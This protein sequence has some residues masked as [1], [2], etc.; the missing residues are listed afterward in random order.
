MKRWLKLTLVT[1][2]LLLGAALAAACAPKTPPEDKNP[3]VTLNHSVYSLDIGGQF[4]LTADVENTQEAVVWT[5]SN[6][7]VASVAGGTVTGTGEGAAEITAAAGGAS[8]KCVVT[9]SAD[10][11]P[12]LDIDAATESIFAGQSLTLRAVVTYKGAT[13]SDAAVTWT[14][15]DTA[16]ATVSPSGVLTGVTA[17]NATVTASCVYDGKTATP[18]SVT[19]AVKDLLFLDISTLQDQVLKTG[20]TLQIN[21]SVTRND[22]PVASP[23]FTYTSSDAAKASVDGSGLITAKSAGRFTVTVSYNGEVSSYLA[24]NAEYTKIFET[25][26]E[27]LPSG[28]TGALK[29]ATSLSVDSVI[30]D[31]GA[32][33]AF[34]PVSGGV[35]VDRSLFDPAKRENN[36]YVVSGGISYEAAFY[37]AL[38]GSSDIFVPNPGADY[39]A[40]VTRNVNEVGR[41]DL[42]RFDG[43]AGETWRNDLI[44]PGKEHNTYAAQGFAVMLI[45]IYFIPDSGNALFS[46]ETDNETLVTLSVGQSSASHLKVFDPQYNLTPLAANQWLTLAWDLTGWDV[47]PAHLWSNGGFKLYIDNVRFLSAAAYEKYL[48][49]ELSIDTSATVKTAY[50][51]SP[52]NLS[53][54][55]LL[56]GQVQTGAAVTWTVSDGTGSATVSGNTLTGISKG[57]VTV[58]ATCAYLGQTA[59]ASFTAEI[60]N[61]YYVTITAPGDQSGLST[62]QTAQITATAAEGATQIVSP[63]FTY[64]SSDVAKASVDVNGLITAKSAG[65]VTIKV[66]Y[67]VSG[68][69]E[70]YST[71]TLNVTY[72][73]ADAAK[74]VELSASGN[75]GTVKITTAFTV[76]S[77][78]NA[79]GQPITLTQVSGGYTADKADL[80][81]DLA[82][83]VLYLNV[84][85]VIYTAVFHIT[86]TLDN[87]A[88]VEDPYSKGMTRSDG[89]SYMGGSGLTHIVGS[90]TGGW[91][92]AWRINL[93]A[94]KTA[95]YTYLLFDA[96]FEAQGQSECYPRFWLDLTADAPVNIPLGGAP[97]TGITLYDAAHNPVT[98]FA[99][100]TLY[101][102]CID[103]SYTPGVIEFFSR[104]AYEM[105]VG[106]L[107]AVTAPGLAAFASEHPDTVAVNHSVIY[108]QDNTVTRTNDVAYKGKSGLVKFAGQYGIKNMNQWF[109]DVSSYKAAGYTYVLFDAYFTDQGD[110]GY[111]RFWIG[112]NAGSPADI[113][114]GNA[115]GAGITLYDAAHN[116]VSAFALDTW[117]TYCIDLT[118]MPAGDKIIIFFAN[119]DYLMYINNIRFA[120]SSGLTAFTSVHPAVVNPDG[121]AFLTSGPAQTAGLHTYGVSYQGKEDLMKMAY[122][123]DNTGTAWYEFWL[124]I[125]TLQYTAAGYGYLLVDL[126]V[127]AS[128][129]NNSIGF[130][131]GVSQDFTWTPFDNTMSI[132]GITVLDDTGASAAPGKG[133]WVTL[134]FDLSSAKYSNSSI[135]ILWS[136]N[137]GYATFYVG[138][139]RFMTTNAYTDYT[140][141]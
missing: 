25:A 37:T 36:L 55:V 64:T 139:A 96:R 19:V 78:K 89:V 58:T 99:D 59:V 40:S 39:R 28:N 17:G 54:S 24:V 30:D 116:S 47:A 81:P 2:T 92:N 140:T 5:T 62:G 128:S 1:V 123:K 138:N 65:E 74:I 50:V 32:P 34:A 49:G 114:V 136:C 77:A 130:Q 104:N 4:T 110:G 69:E 51:G 56:K 98:A 15:S 86:R 61:P 103:L 68:V 8:A 52:V 31:S 22:M 126:W 75:T 57:S 76:D 101:T 3:S 113:Q 21:A 135:F 115:P 13:V 72:T 137:G 53:A 73:A 7:A 94:Y 20:Q 71:V 131:Y 124:G 117:Y 134:A 87:A 67:Y 66:S 45:D 79:A 42:S 107:R 102:Y 93:S 118:Q 48:A 122:S 23:T 33:V 6:A 95:G 105:Y 119:D 60:L 12:S 35:E 88:V 132:D 43:G 106:N 127:D 10:Y 46:F 85:G 109:M 125:Q 90:G 63:T 133:Q 80:D 82:D 70:G 41:T 29:L 38:K 44:I 83:N 14:S 120:V 91:E 9:V 141:P 108:H 11:V 27:L 16:V 112:N 129:S 111:P 121:S 18:Q 26:V 97:G 100:N 84:N